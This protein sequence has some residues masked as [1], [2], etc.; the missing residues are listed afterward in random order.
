MI[1]QAVEAGRA[2][3]IGVT[4]CGE[5][6]ADTLATPL[7]LGLGLEEFSVSAPLIPALKQAIGRWSTAEAES[8]RAR[9]AGHGFERSG[10][11]TAKPASQRVRNKFDP[12]VVQPVIM[13]R[14]SQHRRAEKLFTL[15]IRHFFGRFFDTEALSP[16]GDPQANVT[17][18]LGILA[19]PSAFFVLVFRPLGLFGWSLVAVRY[20]FLSISMIVM[21]FIMV[22]EWDALF[23]DRR[24]YQILTPLPLRLST[25]SWRKPPRSA[26]FSASS[27]WTSISSA[28]L[29]WPG[30]DGGRN[31]VNLFVSHVTAVLA[32]G[33][34][35][36]LAVAAL[37][38]V[39]ITILPAKPYRRVSVTIQTLLMGCW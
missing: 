39:L 1:R 5:L 9:G 38:G 34:F 21:G 7:L 22:F 19:V 25:F 12:H 31:L 24:D 11:A 35:A 30:I 16:Q 26:F 32:G 28:S 8:H 6:A 29:F 37:Q 17:Q 13:S 14:P 15:L 23:P 36:A 20:I 18:T 3:G 2:A 10:P 4:L 33:L 27:C